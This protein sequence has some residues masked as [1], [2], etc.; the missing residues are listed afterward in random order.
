MNFLIT[1]YRYEEKKRKR[2]QKYLHRGFT[3]IEL[4]VVIAIIAL[5]MAIL[6]P[7]LQKARKQTKVIMCQANLK[8]WSLVWSMYTN[9]NDDKFPMFIVNDNLLCSDWRT[10]LVGDLYS[11]EKEMLLCPMTT[12]TLAEGAPA[13]YAITVDNI[14][15]RKSS[16][17]INEYIMN[18]SIID[19]IA[20]D[21]PSH[22][23]GS[24]SVANA[25][26][27]PIM[28]DSAWW[29]KSMPD[30]N[31][32]PPEYDGQPV[33]GATSGEMRIFCINRHDGFINML[34]MDCSVRKV[35][36]KELWTMK[37]HRKYDTMGLWTK[38]GGVQPEDWPPW[39][40]RF[41]D[42]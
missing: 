28:G 31:D 19:G 12:K 15:G 22:Y 2:E 26:N 29:H 9:Q 37:W 16:Y 1:Y 6:I 5:L 39:M 32:L 33:Q 27:I 41:L 10:D 17:A 36:L 18:G 14:F 40:S 30:P 3:L 25:N 24:T 20:Y 4:L 11:N 13:K 8:Q 21:P 38:A 23:W 35:G 7:T 34:F 42:Y